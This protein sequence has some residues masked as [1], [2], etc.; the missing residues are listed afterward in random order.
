[1]IPLPEPGNVSC[2][3]ALARCGLLSSREIAA[4]TGLL[5]PRA[6]FPVA[7]GLAET[8]HVHI[9]VED[10]HALPVNAF[11][12]AGAR[13]DHQRDGFVKYRFPEGVNAIFSHIKVSQ[14]ELL[15]TDTNRRQRPFLD[16][17]GIDLRDETAAVRKAFDAL[18]GIARE[19]S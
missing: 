13:L 5:D 9:K 18:P 4:V 10:T 1:M 14:D 2:L 11:F 17:I 12:D 19:L 6:P 3:H 8:I 7:V 16:H 15:E